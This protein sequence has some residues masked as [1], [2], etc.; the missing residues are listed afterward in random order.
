LY[1]TRG[2]Y[3]PP[4][5][6]QIYSIDANNPDTSLAVL[7]NQQYKYGLNVDPAGA[8]IAFSGYASSEGDIVHQRLYAATLATGHVDQLV[9]VPE[10]DSHAPAWSPTGAEIYFV[11][12]LSGHYEAWSIDV[13]SRRLT[14]RTRAPSRGQECW[15]VRPS[16][17]GSRLALYVIGAREFSGSIEVVRLP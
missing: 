8:R 11:S 10:S 17:D 7:N 15:A 3:G 2:T 4:N 5:I 13:A 12:D 1:F 9:G 6:P 16:P 14:Q